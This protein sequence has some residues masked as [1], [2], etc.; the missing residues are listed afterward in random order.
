MSVPNS[1]IQQNISGS[2]NIFTAT[3]NV[4]ISQTPE[5][6]TDRQAQSNLRILLNKVRTFWIEGVL[7]KS[8]HHAVLIN[9]EKEVQTDSVDHPWGMVLELPDNERHILSPKTDIIEIFNQSTRALLILGEPG[10]GKTTTLLDLARKLIENAEQKISTEPIPV[11]FNL[12]SW[13]TSKSLFDWLVKELSE[14]YQIPRKIGKAWLEENRL[15]PLL[16]GFDEIAEPYRQNCIIAINEF[17]EGYGLPGVV[18]CSRITEYTNLPNRLRLNAAI[19]VQPLTDKQIDLY[20][21]NAIGKDK[22]L[23]ALLK[24]DDLLYNLAKTPLFLS[25]LCLA[26]RSA[27]DE[28]KAISAG[29][30]E[31]YTQKIFDVYFERVLKRKGGKNP[32]TPE[33]IQKHLSWLAKNMAEKSQSVFYIEQLQPSWLSS[34]KEQTTYYAL[35]RVFLWFLIGLFGTIGSTY[36]TDIFFSMLFGITLGLMSVA[37]IMLDSRTNPGWIIH[38]EIYKKLNQPIIQ[39]QHWL[40]FIYLQTI[41]FA[42][43]L[44]LLTSGTPIITNLGEWQ[45]FT[46]NPAKSL[47]IFVICETLLLVLLWKFNN[48]ITRIIR[49]SFVG[50]LGAANYVVY[51]IIFSLILGPAILGVLLL[52]ISLKASEKAFAK[53]QALCKLIIISLAGIFVLF[54]LI[55]GHLEG[56]SLFIVYSNFI[57]LIITIIKTLGGR[58]GNGLNGIRLTEN[59]SRSWKKALPFALITIFSL[60][61]F[62]FTSK[63][64]NEIKLWDLE[65]GKIIST[66]QSTPAHQNADWNAHFSDNGHIIILFSDYS[67]NPQAYLYN[68]VNGKMIAN[69]GIIH[70]PAKMEFNTSGTRFLFDDFSGKTQLWDA[71]TWSL[72]TPLDVNQTL[73]EDEKNEI[74]SFSNSFFISDDFIFTST[75][76][77]RD[78]LIAWNGITGNPVLAFY[79]N[80]N[81]AQMYL[82]YIPLKTSDYISFDIS[83]ARNLTIYDDNFLKQNPIIIQNWDVKEGTSCYWYAVSQEI[84]CRTKPNFELGANYITLNFFA[85]TYQD[86]HSY[87]YSSKTPINFN[88]EFSLQFVSLNVHPVDSSP[89]YTSKL[90]AGT[91]SVKYNDLELTFNTYPFS[92]TFFYEYLALHRLIITTDGNNPLVYGFSFLLVCAIAAFFLVGLDTK[93]IEKRISPNQ[94]IWLSLKNSLLMGGLLAFVFGLLTYILYTLLLDANEKWMYS[95]EY[96]VLAGTIAWTIY[97]GMAFVF[98]HTL[99]LII[100]KRGYFP[101][102]LAP[103]LD[104]CADN[105]LLQKVGGG[106]IFIHR[107]LLENLAKKYQD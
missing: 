107:M 22:T 4:F 29:S 59:L 28:I 31:E 81:N 9:L 48:T 37:V 42:L 77:S 57:G 47:L 85:S 64:T 80:S 94:G 34:Q 12:S 15:L 3:G 101:W 86:I 76:S 87:S 62:I 19:C 35:S 46:E 74:Y 92:R 70:L 7:E 54:Q 68:S 88:P 97:G 69:L 2:G 44:I 26:H 30:A 98:H 43:S 91:K 95:V 50:W 53:I 89:D 6:T 1:G 56:I 65:T 60:T 66:L 11:V 78:K 40:R 21:Q 105:L 106:Y 39:L 45:Y 82:R 33:K 10:S 90:E 63:F 24:K 25:I 100:A 51:P 93:T 8:I 41:V 72:I 23:K 75:D 73:L 83:Q 14:K 99:R 96:G 58:Y 103:F 71:N 55:T 79:Y 32:Y 61:A 104:Y 49:N 102:K 67:Y 5:S 84:N 20:I 52:I 16:D 13:G 36:P 27:P 18:V 38:A 17:I